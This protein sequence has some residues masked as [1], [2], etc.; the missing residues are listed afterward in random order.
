M[1][2][3]IYKHTDTPM[4]IYQTHM[5]K[6]STFSQCVLIHVYILYRAYSCIPIYITH[7]HFKLYML[8]NITHL[9]P[10][11]HRENMRLVIMYYCHLKH[12]YI[13]WVI[14]RFWCTLYSHESKYADY[15]PFTRMNKQHGD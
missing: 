3:H 11:I 1:H 10:S 9:D 13:Q 7:N 15:S 6:L 8:Q 4:Y 2:T 14:Y 5:V 12:S